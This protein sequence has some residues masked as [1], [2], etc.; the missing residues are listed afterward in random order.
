[1][2]A[3]LAALAQTMLSDVYRKGRYVH[4]P[5]MPVPPKI[6]GYFCPVKPVG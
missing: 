5:G 1:M 3:P 6:S 2:A 4:P